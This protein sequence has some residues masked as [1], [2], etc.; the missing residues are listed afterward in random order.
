MGFGYRKKD[1]L[2]ISKVIFEKVDIS[3]EEYLK[4]QLV[5]VHAVFNRSTNKNI[6]V[7]LN[8]VLL[9][10]RLWLE[11]HVPGVMLNIMTIEEVSEYLDL[12]YK[13]NE[14]YFITNI[15]RLSKWLWYW[16]SMRLKIPHFNVGDRY[17]DAL[18][19]R[20][21]YV[22]MALDEIEML[23]YQGIN[24]D[25]MD[26]M[27]YHFNYLISLFT[28][29]F[30]NLA[31]RTNDQM[32]IKYTDLKK[33]SLNNDDFL[34]D[35]RNMNA[36]LREHIAN[37]RNFIRL[38]YKFRELV[39]HREG[40]QTSSFRYGSDPSWEANFITIS[41]EM[42]NRINELNRDYLYDPFTI[43]GY[44]SI[45]TFRRFL[46][47][48]H[49]SKEVTKILFNFVDKYLKLLGFSSFIEEQ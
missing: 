11:N 8:D 38:I 48:Y 25:V 47:P 35:I 28:G 23:F 6:F 29:I 13:Y 17:I 36:V 2:D 18:A 40:L 45:N 20:A 30:D 31:L 16:H 3:E 24:N 37:N 27:L 12:I 42:G 33:V 26:S 39:I 49:F 43:M 34:I 22:L 4:T 41:E 10:N 19:T 46:E 21:T 14:K 9:R 32:G 44:Y 15:R 7:T 1:I 5:F